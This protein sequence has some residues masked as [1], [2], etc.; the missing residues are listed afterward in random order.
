[1]A[2]K[3]WISFHGAAVNVNTDLAAFGQINP[4]GLTPEVM[5]SMEQLLGCQTDLGEFAAE[6]VAQYREVFETEFT[7]IDLDTLAEDVESQSGSN[8]I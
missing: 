4:C 5:T 1:V 2:V 6:L 7:P 8:A 3:S